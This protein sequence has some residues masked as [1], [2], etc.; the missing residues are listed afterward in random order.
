MA[1]TSTPPPPPGHRAAGFLVLLINLS[2][3]VGACY[4]VWHVYTK[5]APT[6]VQAADLEGAVPTWDEDT[7]DAVRTEDTPRIGRDGP[8]GDGAGTPSGR[9][10]SPRHRRES[11]TRADVQLRGIGAADTGFDH[12]RVAGYGAG[13]V[14]H[15]A[16]T[17]RT[18]DAVGVQLEVLRAIKGSYPSSVAKARELQGGAHRGN[19]A[20]VSALRAAGRFPKGLDTVDSDGDGR[21]EIV[22]AW[23]RA[24]VYFSADD[25][26]SSQSLGQ[27]SGRS[28]TGKAELTASTP[29]SAMTGTFHA[30]ARFQMWS[31]GPDGLNDG[32]LGDDVRSWLIHE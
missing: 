13:T 32:G 28:E 20:V 3:L 23:G 8:V 30:A 16:S 26:G 11:R 18:I 22:D 24:L 14:E 1:P 15:V 19:E 6:T 2:L 5:G 29:R 31:L 17:E 25:Y 4:W 7:P 9:V 10:A 27:S 21:A 12:V